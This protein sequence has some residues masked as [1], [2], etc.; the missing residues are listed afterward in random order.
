MKFW[1]LF[2]AFLVLGPSLGAHNEMRLTP[3]IPM[4]MFEDQCNLPAPANLAVTN[5]GATDLSFSW[6][7][8][9]GAYAYKVELTKVSTNTVV[10]SYTGLPQSYTSTISSLE[11]GTE[12]RFDIWSMCSATETGGLSSISETTHNFIIDELL[13]NYNG[14]QLIPGNPFPLFPIQSNVVRPL[15]FKIKNKEFESKFGVN[16]Q[17]QAINGGVHVK[18]HNG[19]S[20]IQFVNHQYDNAQDAGGSIPSDNPGYVLLKN[21]TTT[22][23]VLEYRIIAQN[24]WY[25]LD[26]SQLN[27][28]GFSILQIS[29][30]VGMG[31][32]NNPNNTLQNQEEINRVE[33]RTESRS[34]DTPCSIRPNPFTDLLTVQG[35]T[36]ANV[37]LLDI[38]GKLIYQ[39]SMDTTETNITIP[40]ADLAKGVYLVR[41]E[42]A[43]SVK[44]IKVVKTN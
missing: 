6:D 38:N 10:Y 23:P 2:L 15:Q 16:N 3:T 18:H 31:V 21:A 32:V 36:P 27:N 4:E 41:Y 37:Q 7:G 9:V 5:V 1:Y 35:S 42:T 26:W 24:G 19:G 17:I 44:T 20:N 8:V 25:Y 11:P 33:E 39:Y 28:S 43:D 13:T 30:P 14:T 34:T 29:N 12:Y 22:N 40:T